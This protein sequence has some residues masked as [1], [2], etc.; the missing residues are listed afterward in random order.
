[1]N[2]KDLGK[3]LVGIIFVAVIF[4]SSFSNLLGNFWWF[5]ALNYQNVFIRILSYKVGAF[6][7]ASLLSGL[8]LTVG[9]RWTIHNIRKDKQYVD[10]KWPYLTIALASVVIGFS[11][12]GAWDVILKFLHTTPFNVADPVFAQDVAFYT[13]ELP[14]Y[15][16]VV[17]FLTT[18][19]ILSL[20]TSLFLYGAYFASEEYEEIE[21]LTGRKMQGKNFNFSNFMDKI[22]EYA[23][24]HLS[25]F[26]AFIFLTIAANVFFS[27]FDLLYSEMGAVFGIGFTEMNVTLLVL[28]IISIV[29]LIGAVGLFANAWLKKKWMIWGTVLTLVVIAIIGNIASWGV[30]SLV[31]EPDEF[32]KEKPFI[33]NEIEFTRKAYNLNKVAEEQFP[34]SPN[35]TKEEINANP[36]TIENVRLWDWRPLLKTYNEL[37][38]FRTYYNFNDVDVDRYPINNKETQVM[39]SARE[40]D[41]DQL[42]PQSQSWVNKHLV[43]THGYGLTMSP[44]REVSKEGLPELIVKD[45]PPKSKHINIEQPRIYYGENTH[46]Y[47][48]VNTQTQE[49]DYPSGERNVYTNYEGEG[50]VELSLFRRLVYAIAFGDPQ[51]FFSG[52]ITPDSQLQFHRSIQDRVRTLAPFL[53]YDADPY[54]A[55]ADGEMY[56]IYDAYTTTDKYPYSKK[57]NF[58]DERINY[59]RNSVKVVVNAYSGETNFYVSNEEDPIIQTYRDIFPSLFKDFSQM[60][61]SLKEHIRYPEDIFRAQSKMYLDYHMRDPNVFY[62]KEDSWRIPNEVLRGR[63]TEMEPYYI[64]MKLPQ[65]DEAEFMQILPFIPRGKENMIGWMAARSDPP[66]YGELKS[67]LF[68]KQEL[69]FGPMQIESRI[70]QDTEIS[71]RITL[72]SQSGSSVFRGNLL[73]IPIEDTILYVEPLFLQSRGE[74]SLPELKRVIVAQGDRLTMQPTLD[75]GLNA[76]YGEV[77]QTPVQPQPPVQDRNMSRL[78]QLYNEAS[79]ALQRGDLAT[80]AEKVRHIGQEIGAE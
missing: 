78:R 38:I 47:N 41:L 59:I 31:V 14:F 74:G 39:V 49:L 50:G 76:L 67:Y 56:W 2:L 28:L 15:K 35:L 23:N 4:L 5:E 51:I 53:K 18:T 11:F 42:P 30:Q 60:S 37:Q 29:A 7:V 57:M 46:T 55:V 65:E 63:N 66:N 58:K 64:I 12:T 75:E 69:I 44:V 19:F 1:M 36:E 48:I 25:L 40:I 62:N 20:L 68:S 45:I 77:N 9:Y 32:N 54:I 73:P 8:I 52:S 13:F 17:S 33:E 26:L 21:P 72:W 16:T 80:Y 34:V 61:E 27:R 70:D 3:W 24:V 43:Y 6:L 22:S 10:S 79:S 71:Q